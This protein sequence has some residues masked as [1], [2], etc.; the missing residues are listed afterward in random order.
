M[1]EKAKWNRKSD[2]KWENIFDLIDAICFFIWFEVV[3]QNL[4]LWWNKMDNPLQMDWSKNLAAPKLWCS[5]GKW[6]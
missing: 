4:V 1:E 3:F 5:W 2:H 6:W